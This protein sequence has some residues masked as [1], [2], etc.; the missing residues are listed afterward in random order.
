MGERGDGAASYFEGDQARKL[1]EAVVRGDEKEIQR[2]VAKG[3][4][5]NMVGRDGITPL[6]LAM[7][8]RNLSTFRQLLE[9]GADANYL[10]GGDSAVHFAAAADD[11]NWLKLV[12]QH[13][14]DPNLVGKYGQTPLFGALSA[15]QMENLQLLIQSGAD[16]N[17]QDSTGNTAMMRAAGLNRY[18]LVLTLLDA[19]ADY[20]VTDHWGFSLADDIARS[21][22]D[23]NN[24]LYS[25]RERVIQW[26][27]KRGV[28][29]EL[30][31]TQ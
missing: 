14:G 20:R 8:R 11:L 19:G 10:T 13:G 12:L 27:E 9:L 29:I 4:N 31:Q 25:W 7:L 22:V 18:D 1:E 17:H 5:V 24:E 30:Q 21:R 6:L 16:L 26:L 23:P 15:I 28:T 3:A 2:L